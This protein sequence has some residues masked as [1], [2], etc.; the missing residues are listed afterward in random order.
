MGRDLRA[1]AGVVSKARE[2]AEAAF[3]VAEADPAAALSQAALAAELLTDDEPAVA[4]LVEWCRGL[5]LRGLGRSLEAAAALRRALEA[6]LAIGDAAATGRIRVTLAFEEL[7]AGRGD[8]ALELL[9]E[10]Q[11]TLTGPDA[12]EA[13]MQ[14]AIVL[15]RLGRVADSLA[16]FSHVVERFHELGMKGLEAKA[17]GNRGVVL[18]YRGEYEAAE[19]DLALA[20]R[21]FSETGD[22][23]WA[24]FATHNLG[25]VA[26]RRGNLP[27]A[28]RLFDEAQ[29]QLSAAGGLRPATLTDRVETMLD[30]GLA[31]EARAVLEAAI[32]DLEGQGL[33]ADLAEA[34]YLAI[35]ACEQDGDLAAARRWAERACAL[36]AAQGRPSWELLA[37]YRLARAAHFDG[38]E[39]PDGA[40]ML[41]FARQLHEVG[42]WTAAAEAEW[43]A[44]ELDAGA[45]ALEAALA[46][47][48][49]AAHRRRGALAAVRF[50]G[51]IAEANVQRLA[52]EHHKAARAVTAAFAALDDFRAG[53]GST[54]LRSSA[55]Q[56]AQ[57]AEELGVALSIEAGRPERALH[58]MERAR[59]SLQLGAVGQAASPEV[60]QA[61]LSLREI[62]AQLAHDPPPPREQQRLRRQELALEEIVRRSV[63]HNEVAAVATS[64]PLPAGEL[65]AALGERVL[66]EYGVLAGRVV[67]IVRW[68]RHSRLVDLAALPAAERAVVAL[69]GAMGAAARGRAGRAT[70][71]VEGAARAVD[72][73][74]VAPLLSE[75]PG[76]AL[77]AAGVVVVPA[78]PLASLAWSVLESL[79]ELPVVVA[80]SVSEWARR[81][82]S[83]PPSGPTAIV[84]GPELAFAD[85]EVSA[86]AGLWGRQARIVASGEATVDAVRAAIAGAGVAHLAAHGLFRSDNPL[87]SAIRFT[88]GA[89]TGYD[90]TEMRELPSIVVLSACDLGMSGTGAAAFGLPS[91]LIASG[92]RAVVASVTPV[93]DESSGRLML[94]LHRFLR[95]GLEPSAA[96]VAARRTLG[97]PADGFVSFGA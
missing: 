81:R 57:R 59:G 36:F 37:R 72:E 97:S 20:R 96:L 24:G 15:Q 94:E 5:A 23:V 91:L 68:A 78:G 95:E 28:L 54:E 88:D 46:V 31:E 67:A 32:V 45:G 52:G 60:R 30:A 89:L 62:G 85:A 41:A 80:N 21:L 44:A 93:P 10:A 53:L 74:L 13:A 18:A 92:T 50:D 33:E 26:S 56:R 49:G 73:L 64:R 69:H 42:W 3:A 71:S 14:R 4:A 2:E 84:A 9:D 6:H 70:T 51:W 48:R 7:S 40:R 29:R 47:L 90:L 38:G 82:S 63:R 25:F 12:A 27:L 1:P 66:F 39:H 87:L 43:L 77:P 17:R 83:P 86:L 61:L 65:S 22:A 76:A 8:L 35:R 16:A 58:W 11:E 34:C 55:A 19:T 75:L 79:G